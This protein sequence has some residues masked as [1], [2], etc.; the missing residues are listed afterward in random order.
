MTTSGSSH[1]YRRPERS[2]TGQPST[3]LFRIHDAGH[4]V[5]GEH[6]GRA[7]YEQCASLLPGLAQPMAPAW[8][9]LDESVRGRWCDYAARTLVAGA[10]R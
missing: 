8:Q 6:E 2:R 10:G 4:N 3:R 7:L 9:E 5:P 1:G